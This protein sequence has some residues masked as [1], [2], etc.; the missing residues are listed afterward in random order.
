LRRGG[1]GADDLRGKGKDERNK[2]RRIVEIGERDKS[3][4]EQR[5]KIDLMV[6]D[7]Q[8]REANMAF[9]KTGGAGA[10]RDL[11]P[12]PRALRQSIAGCII[13]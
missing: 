2:V 9:S 12:A 7:G 4:K 8:A 6:E 5:L 10:S 1:E 3:S 11:N 13:G